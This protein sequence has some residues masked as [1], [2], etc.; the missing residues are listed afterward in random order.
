MI[1]NRGSASKDDSLL[2]LLSERVLRPIFEWL[3]TMDLDAGSY[4]SIF[5]IPALI[6]A[7]AATEMP[8]IEFEHLR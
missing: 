5:D 1:Q 8:T 6:P 2:P 4:A 7:T 3:P